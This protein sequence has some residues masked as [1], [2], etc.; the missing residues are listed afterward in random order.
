MR[1]APS[2][3]I[4]GGNDEALVFAFET[5]P[6]SLGKEIAITVTFQPPQLLFLKIVL[7]HYRPL[8]SL[9]YRPRNSL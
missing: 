2:L 9:P 6:W 7:A 8:L 4:E 1:G 5:S 3:L